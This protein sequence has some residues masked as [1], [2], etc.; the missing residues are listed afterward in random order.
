MRDDR[1]QMQQSDGSDRPANVTARPGRW[2]SDERVLIAAA[3]TLQERV[4]LAG[5]VFLALEFFAALDQRLQAAAHALLHIGRGLVALRV[6]LGNLRVGGEHRVE[7][8][9]RTER[10]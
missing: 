8:V 4:A 10:R 1:W 3:G 5:S 6:V 2:G 7:D 9:A